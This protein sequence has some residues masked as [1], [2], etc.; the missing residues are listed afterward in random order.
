MRWY[1]IVKYLEMFI[2]LGALPRLHISKF[3]A[4]NYTAA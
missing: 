1:N 2:A 3:W 4:I